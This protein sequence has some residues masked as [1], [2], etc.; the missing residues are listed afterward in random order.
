MNDGAL[1]FLN[2]AAY[3]W[4]LFVPIVA[5]KAWELKVRLA[6]PV[7]RAAA[8]A[9]LANLASSV[10]AT[11]AVFAAGWLLGLLDFI[12]TTGTGEGDAAA[13]AAIVPC[14][15]LSVWCESLVAAQLLRRVSLTD[16]R[17]A[18]FQANLFGYSV[19]A[20]VPVVRFVKSAIVNGHIIW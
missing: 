9:A 20:I 4:L 10:L 15:F 2:F 17:A 13:L 19:L 16:L 3:A 5:I 1:L 7:G 14:F 12:A 11:A 8:V 18:V 6:L